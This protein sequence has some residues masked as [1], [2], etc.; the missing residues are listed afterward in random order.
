[1]GP[2]GAYPVV[3]GVVV[4]VVAGIGGEKTAGG[5]EGEER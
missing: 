3:I 1:M 2:A 4:V 5:V